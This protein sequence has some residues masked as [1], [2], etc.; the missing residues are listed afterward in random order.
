MSAD[1]ARRVPGTQGD[2]LKVVQNLPGV[3]RP[4]LASGQLVVWGS[5]PNDT[6]VL[7]DGVEVPAL[8]HGSGLRSVVSSDFVSSVELSPGAF[9]AE[10]G[11]GLGGLVRVDSRN[12]AKDGPHT[13]VA[14]DTLD[15]AVMHSRPITKDV[16]ASILARYSYLDALVPL[17]SS[18]DVGSTF[19]IPRYGDFQAKTTFDLGPRESV[20]IVGLGS[21]D[22]LDRTVSSPDP[23]SVRSVQSRSSFERVYARW[24]SSSQSQT[25]VVTPFAGYEDSRQDLR[26]G[27]TPAT[28]DVGSAVYGLRASRREKVG[29][30]AH[31]TVG[32]DALGR[33]S[34]VSRQ[35]SLTLPPREGDV[36]VFGQP[37]G[38]DVASDR[39]KTHVLNVA[40]DIATDIALGPATFTLGVRMENYLIEGSRQTPKVGLTPEIGFSRLELAFDPRA[41]ARVRVADGLVVTAAGGLYR[42]APAPEDLS[43]VF[44]T[45]ALSVSKATHGSLAEEVR[46]TDT[47]TVEIT[48]FVKSLSDLPVRTQLPSPI[49]ARV[50]TQ[51]GEGRSFGA[52]L[53]VRQE[54]TRG[55]FAWLSYTISRSERRNVGDDRYRLFDYDQPHVLA[56]VASYEVGR[57]TFGLRF[58]AS[59]GYPR[60]PV[61]AST[62]D[63]KNDRYDPVFGAQNATRLPAFYQL[64]AKVDRVFPLGE[65]R[66]LTVYLDVEN[67][68]AHDNA[69]EYVYSFDYARRGIITGPPTIAVVGARL[70]F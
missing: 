31:V 22:A 43:A 64:D 20:D 42:Q 4:P 10:Y 38:D 59:S 46:V 15:S 9:G 50:L 55:F 67:V 13:F 62:Y 57:F 37:P 32:M 52:Q 2:V 17:V 39:E 28:L 47:T 69:E 27:G 63:A 61:N 65:G 18:K 5:A 33:A 51:N 16:R 25:S 14:A 44:G 48:E 11:R 7:I 26:F 66:K 68:T 34:T 3:S 45:P 19:P 56:A 60:T 49:L 53:L 36:S 1:E 35:G 8:Y 70:D 23:G 12:I 24:V 54:L 58:R 21:F 41:A 40:P 29:E 30:R 6:R